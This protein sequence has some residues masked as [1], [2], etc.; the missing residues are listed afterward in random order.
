MDIIRCEETNYLINKWHNYKKEN[1]IQWGSSLRVKS[2]QVAVFVYKKDEHTYQDYISG[3]FDKVLE[4]KNLPIISNIIGLAYH[5]NSP[6]QAEVY[7]INLLNLI[8][9]N[10][11]IPYF[12]VFD[13]K[14]LD[15]SVP[16]AVR[17]TL[18]LKINDYKAFL[19]YYGLR[20]LT[21][22][23]FKK[24]INSA[25]TRYV[26]G[27][28]T[29]IPVECNLSVLKMETL[30]NEINTI[31]EGVVKTRL[32]RDFG[33]ELTGLDIDNIE[34][35]KTSE[36]YNNLY[37]VSKKLSIRRILFKDSLDKINESIDTIEKL[38]KVIANICVKIGKLL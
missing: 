3:P 7:F 1:A 18:N 37:K 17:G 32:D 22:D 11:G 24:I 34:I 28:I 20:D 9:L 16:I 10:F 4:T 25:L 12:D 19:A 31:L 2:G 26:K 29:N 38:E 21:I 33:V 27:T 35:D 30:I 15:L 13:N 6:F 36:D 8:Q 5:G 14:Y 23:D